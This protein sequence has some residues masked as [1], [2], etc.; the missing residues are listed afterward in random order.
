MSSML[1]SLMGQLAGGNLGALSKAVGT[2]EKATQGALA[3]ALPMLLAGLAKNSA[4]EDGAA[5]LHRALEK[6]HDGAL[7][8]D[9]SGFLGKG[10]S[11]PGEGILRHVFGDRRAAIER[12][13][14]RSAGIDPAQ[15]ARLLAMAAPMI[16]AFLGRQRRQGALDPAALGRMLG[17]QNRSVQQAAPQLG[18]LARL[19]DAD[20]DGSIADD[21]AQNVLGKLFRR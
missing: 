3:A 21:I 15:A 16:M 10:D 2:D 13:V 20:G 18:G 14:S 19:L 1:E 9:V 17:D 8:D 12:G 6:D 11:T 7:L 4:Q 5:A